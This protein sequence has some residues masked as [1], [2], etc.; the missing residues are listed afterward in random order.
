M[1]ERRKEVGEVRQFLE[2]TDHTEHVDVGRTWLVD[3][4]PAW[5]LQT[6]LQHQPLQTGRDAGQTWG[7]V[8]MWGSIS[9]L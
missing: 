2:L 4:K 5:S 9:L 8:R 3:V 7:V 1:E 6:A